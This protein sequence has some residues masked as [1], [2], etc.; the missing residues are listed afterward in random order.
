M[1]KTT[2]KAHPIMILRLMKPYLFILILPLIRAL[3]QYI[4]KGEI[5]G[6]LALEIIAFCFILAIAILRWRSISIT[7]NDRY[8]TVKKGFL[9]KTRAVIEV[10]RLSSVSLKQNIFDY[11][12]RSVDC[13]VNTEAGTPKKS[14]FSLK[15]HINDAKLLFK[16]IY[17]E[18]ERQTV[19]FSAYRIALLAA[20]TSSAASGIIV[21]VPIINQASDL[22]G[23]AISDMLLSE[24]N[25][26]S[27]RFNNI[28]PPIVNTVTIILLIAYGVSFIISFIKNVNFKLK[29][30]KDGVEVQ[31]GIIVRK[32]IIFKKS[33]INNI[34]F[35]QTP[36]MR[37]IKKYSMRVSVGGYGD[38]KGDAAVIVPI[39]THK[40]L[41]EQ[42]AEHFP[43]FEVNG[44]FI[45]PLQTRFNLNRF[46]YIPALLALLI[47]GIGA[48]LMIIFPYFDRLV[49][50]LM[51]VALCVDGYY[52]SVCYHN[53]KHGGLNIS[54]CVQASGSAGFTV[55]ELYCEKNRIGVIKISQ[56][57]ADRQF[58]TCKIKITVRS[59]NADS[60][61]V[62]N[63]DTSTVKNSL[64]EQ[65]EL[66]IDE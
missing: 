13:E 18:E 1:I 53:Y 35:E 16:L 55:R 33:K 22:L 3:I 24:I 36:L 41:E 34:C 29:S 44:S 31:S 40:E 26:V 57:P 25:N 11:I 60:V 47:L 21:G 52:A 6:L 38:S 23:V 49:L 39:A 54:D 14:D 8:V 7:V 17:G 9:I 5:N 65:F 20:T 4:T 61:R 27:S 48:A 30:G 2:F 43:S 10:S 12:F 28:F 32:R 66:N 15:M 42:F 51:V 46:L 37:L 63:I 58:K 45:R 62:K 19:K 50:F 64:R 56:T 59:E